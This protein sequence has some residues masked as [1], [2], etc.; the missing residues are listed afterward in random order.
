MADWADWVELADPPATPESRATCPIC[1]DTLG[2]PINTRVKDRAAP[3][4]CCAMQCRRETRPSH[5]AAVIVPELFEQFSQ[6]VTVKAMEGE[7]FYCPM[8][9]CSEVVLKPAIRAGQEQTSCPICGT[10]VKWVGTTVSRATRTSA[11]S[12]G[13]DHERAQLMTLKMGWK[14]CPKCCVLVERSMGCNFMRCKWYV[15]SSL[16][17]LFTSHAF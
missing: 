10:A 4:T 13:G 9:E 17:T 6:L 12:T 5:V 11:W 3:V 8:K 16:S 14:Q 15:R 7:S 1:M 2:K